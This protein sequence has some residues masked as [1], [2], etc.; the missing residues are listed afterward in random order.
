MSCLLLLCAVGGGGLKMRHTIFKCVALCRDFPNCDYQIRESFYLTLWFSEQRNMQ[1]GHRPP[2]PT[3][4]GNKPLATLYPTQATYRGWPAMVV[5]IFPIMHIRSER[6][7]KLLFALESKE[8]PVISS[9]FVNC[10]SPALS[11][12]MCDIFWPVY[13]WILAPPSS[14]TD[15]DSFED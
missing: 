7:L 10:L 12:A 14:C 3:L 5:Q 13:L 1:Q 2:N 6:L 8:R 9:W 15:L 11:T 4:M